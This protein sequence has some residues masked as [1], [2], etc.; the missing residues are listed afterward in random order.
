MDELSVEVDSQGLVAAVERFGARLE[1]RLLANARVTGARIR[2]DARRRVRRATGQTADE[3]V[4]EDNRAGTGV[5]VYVNTQGTT[6]RRDRP[7]QYRWP[8]LDIGLEFGTTHMGGHAYM[9]PA[10]EANRELHDRRSREVVQDAIDEEGL[11]G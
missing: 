6:P 5:V 7:G 3:I 9:W 1:S 10:V 8:N 2:D 4:T 11:G